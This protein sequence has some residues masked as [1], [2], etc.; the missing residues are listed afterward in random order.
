MRRI[1]AFFKKHLD[2]IG[3]GGSIVAVLCCLG[4]PVLISILGSI[5]LGF[6]IGDPILI[7]LLV[8]FL[9]LT[10]GGLFFSVREHHRW[11]AVIVGV[12]SA[13]ILLFSVTVPFNRPLIWVG[14]TG[15][16]SS[17]IINVWVRALPSEQ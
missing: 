15:L 5:G 3:V 6:L 16:I 12:I 7:P 14:V 2:K 1:K 9:L 11:W 10:L 17:S 13:A 4:V 8:G